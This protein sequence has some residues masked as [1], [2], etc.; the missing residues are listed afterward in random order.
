MKRLFYNSVF[1]LKTKQVDSKFAKELK[2]K[3][4]VIRARDIRKLGFTIVFSISF[5][6]VTFVFEYLLKLL[7]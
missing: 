7:F 4:L 1:F 5:V 2:E 6:A 3:G